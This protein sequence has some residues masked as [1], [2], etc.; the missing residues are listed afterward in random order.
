MAST[1]QDPTAEGP[2]VVDA[3][4]AGLRLDAFL[5]RRKLTPSSSAARRAVAS[6]VV[7]VNGR[8]ARKGV[9]LVTGDAVD[10]RGGPASDVVLL[11]APRL[12]LTVLYQD[13][14]I[15]A[16]DK[17]AGLASHPLRPDDGATLAAALVARFPECAAASPGSSRRRPRPS[18]RPRH[19]GRAP[20]GSQPRNLV[21][22]ARGPRLPVLRQD[23]P[24]RDPRAIPRRAQRGRRV[25]RRRR[26]TRE[27][28]RHGAHRPAGPSRWSGQA[29]VGPAAPGRAHRNRAGRGAQGK[30]ARR[31][32]SV[33]RPGPPSPRSP[34][35]PRHSGHGRS[36]STARRRRMKDCACTPG[37]LLAAPTH[38]KTLAHRSARARLG[39]EADMKASQHKVVLAAS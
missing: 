2:F 22:P 24:G 15:V 23:L 8:V 17:P 33:T 13:E 4:E 32:S 14:A 11:P 20:R 1:L 9:H 3:G 28:R 18:P 16:L 38:R 21:P 34:R 19:F 35:L 10:L 5:A 25:R 7:R 27:L 30:R 6:G 12:D 26:A 29:R 31:G 36:P 39:Q 37:R